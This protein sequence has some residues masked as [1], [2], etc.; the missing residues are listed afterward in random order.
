MELII[1]HREREAK[2]NNEN[3][4][5]CPLR[6][7]DGKLSI[8]RIMCLSAFIF[9]CCLALYSV[10]MATIS[11]NALIIGQTVPIIVAF[12]T[13]AG[14]AKVGGGF[15]EAIKKNSSKKAEDL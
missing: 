8:T 15:A 7:H 11:D 6:D 1:L 3:K 2:M 9:A 4:K 13:F 12:L 10:G 14:T 5:N